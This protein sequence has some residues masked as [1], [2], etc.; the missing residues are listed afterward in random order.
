MYKVGGGKF[1]LYSKGKYLC[2]QKPRT[3]KTMTLCSVSQQQ[4]VVVKIIPQNCIP[5]ANQYFLQR[6]SP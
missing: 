3:A 6:L 4:E 2:L 5:S 1:F